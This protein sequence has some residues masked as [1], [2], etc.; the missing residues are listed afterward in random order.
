VYY[1]VTK[2]NDYGKLSGNKVEAL[3]EGAR[4]E[5]DPNK[6]NPSDFA[7]WKSRKP[8]EP[9]WYSPWGPGRPG[10]HIECSAMS[11]RYLGESFDV[12]AGGKDLI[13]PHHENEIAQ[14][15]AAS[16]KP[17]AKYWL[18]NEWLTINGEKMSKSLGNVITVRD[19][20][21]RYGAQTLRMFLVSAHYRSPVDFNEKTLEQAM[22]NIERIKMTLQAFMRLSEDYEKSNE[23]MELL[24]YAEDFREAFEEAMDDDF[25]TPKAFASVFEFLTRINE[26]TNSNVRVSRETK[27]KVLKIVYELVYG[28]LGIE[29]KVE[30]SETP[31][32]SFNLLGLII[33]VRSKLR[34]RKDYETADFIRAKLEELGFVI[35]DSAKGTRWKF[36]GEKSLTSAT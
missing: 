25:N 17:L 3:L 21:S 1:D 16:G 22:R 26:Y 2:F 13:F 4:V 18:H 15:E 32:L 30:S 36:R 8:G 33:D 31:N 23:E 27:A 35:E 29:T 11:S 12:H 5:V 10:W 20:I 6:K 28:V 9:F 7:L 14:S 24:S 19:A 34:E